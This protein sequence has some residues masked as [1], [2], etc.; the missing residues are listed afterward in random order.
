MGE[1]VSIG[2]CELG[3]SVVAIDED[4]NA[5]ANL[6]KG[7]VPVE[8]PQI[9]E[10]ANKYQSSGQLK[11]SS[12]YKDL[13]G[14]EA[15]F[16]TFDTP[17]TE[18]DEPDTAVLFSAA[19]NMAPHLK[20]EALL[21][22]MSQ[23][24]VGTTKALADI[25]KREAVYFPENL[26]LGKA[27]V[28]FLKPDRLVIGSGTANIPDRLEAIIKNLPGPRFTM[29]IASAE[30]SK[31]ALNAFL[32]TSL[33]FIFSISDLCE[34]VGADINQ[35]SMALKSDKR[36]GSQAYLNTGP[37]FSGGTLM[38]DLRTLEQLG[39]AHGVGTKLMHGVIQTNLDR[40]EH[41]LARLSHA[42]NRSW[43]QT[44]IGILGV[45][46]KP[47]TPT[48]RRSLALELIQMLK[49]KGTKVVAF[50]PMASPE[51]F[52]KESG[53][54][55]ARDPYAMA[56][57]CQALMLITEWPEFLSLD[58]KRLRESM[59]EPYLFFDSRNF[60]VDKIQSIKAAGLAYLGVGRA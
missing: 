23:V 39:A 48:L 1:V 47:G 52:Q 8:E 9:A 34:A 50:D 59:D 14:C 12:N 28:C 45:T 31:H 17:V 7:R 49:N 42:L 33:S 10:L 2:L 56:Q 60:L 18:T 20:L 26:Q 54:E 44:T 35:V 21:V 53:G 3:H 25:V 13:A 5:I 57:G 4:I 27:L 51:D 58:F 40:P 29:D 30:M 41:I 6:Q 32:A 24:P 36:V 16:L 19:K 15:V 38:R 43:E 22:V 46:Y 55:L 37:G 11:F